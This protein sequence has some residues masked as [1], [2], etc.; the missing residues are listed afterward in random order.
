[1]KEVFDIDQF[2]YDLPEDRIAKYPLEKRDQSKLLLWEKGQISHHRFDEAPN[3][4]P[5]N[6]LLVFNDTKVISARLLFKK[7]TGANIEIFLLHPELPTRDI[8]E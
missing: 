4:I 3:I 6:S 8:Q 1:V 5:A 2:N 7:S